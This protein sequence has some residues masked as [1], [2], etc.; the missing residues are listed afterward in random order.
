M[1]TANH[2]SIALD[3]FKL[4]S[5]ASSPLPLR[6]RKD[7]G[8]LGH[9]STDTAKYAKR[10]RSFLATSQHL[11]Q[12]IISKNY[13]RI[14]T[15]GFLTGIDFCQEM[16]LPC[17]RRSYGLKINFK[18]TIAKVKG[19]IKAPTNCYASLAPFSVFFLGL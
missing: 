11:S 8:V 15:A 13:E 6:R 3:F 18:K 16:S 19:Q 14:Y 1:Q 4:I 17:L 9:H 2:K 12:S 10:C 7:N 5:E